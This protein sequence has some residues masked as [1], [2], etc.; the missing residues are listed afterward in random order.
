MDERY[1]A[2]KPLYNG[3]GYANKPQFKA[4][5]TTASVFSLSSLVLE[6]DLPLGG[7]D[8]DGPN[9]PWI[10]GAEIAK[11]DP[12]KPELLSNWTT[13]MLVIHGDRDCR[14]PATQGLAAFMTLQMK[15]TP[16]RFLRF[17]DEGHLI[18]GKENILMWY[19]VLFEWMAR[20]SSAKPSVL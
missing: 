7:P 14:V 1:L 4:L 15:G 10:N 20:Y 16:S 19:Q 13:P 12:S 8:F 18:E 9:Y 5:A 6:S 17:E 3:T 2:D 11:W